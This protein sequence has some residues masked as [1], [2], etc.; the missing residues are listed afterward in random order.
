M[1]DYLDQ[2]YVERMQ[3]KLD[4]Y[5]LHST[6]PFKANFRCPYCGDSQ[7]SKYKARAWFIEKNNL[8]FFHCFNCTLS[9]N[10]Y[11]FIND[12][13]HSLLGSYTA[14]KYLEKKG[15]VFN[16]SKKEEKL[17]IVTK[18]PV[19]EDNSY[20]KDA[21]RLSDLDEDHPA[22]AYAEKVREIPDIQDIWYSSNF[23][24]L[25]NKIVPGKL[26]EIKH[27]PRIIFPFRGKDKKIF[28]LAGRSL[29]PDSKMRYITIMLDENATKI[30]GLDKV[31]FSK[32]YY[33]VEG[34]IDSYFLK[35]SIAMSGADLNFSS[36]ENSENSVFVFDNE[37]RNKEIVARMEKIVNMG[38]SICVWPEIKG[39]DLN[40]M[41]LN[42][43]DV[44]KIVDDNTYNGL[45]AKAKISEWRKV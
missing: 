2:R 33:I 39:K 27:D 4:R 22:R 9:K 12:N 10:L 26:A 8:I 31:D 6:L 14:E 42:K 44:K 7:K 38:Y 13:D 1:A 34:Q 32:K 36:L 3:F 40:D 11:Q 15:S 41:F 43:Y 24:N 30:F 5:K 19:F 29:N 20:L 17:K 16:F 25:I 21:E 28:G 45:M 37:P 23:S 18:K 35:N